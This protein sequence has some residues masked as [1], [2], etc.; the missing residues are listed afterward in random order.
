MI[1]LKGKPQTPLAN[2]G[3]LLSSPVRI[4]NAACPA[5]DGPIYFS[6]EKFI[7]CPDCGP[8][9]AAPRVDAVLEIPAGIRPGRKH[10]A[11][12]IALPAATRRKAVK[13]CSS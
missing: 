8:A 10:K 9:K 7:H 11:L 3:R 2:V 1:V 6:E 4:S 13:S 5:C 12:M